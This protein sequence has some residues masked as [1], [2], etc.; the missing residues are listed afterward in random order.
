MS[1]QDA[2]GSRA[3]LV[4]AAVTVVLVVVVLVLGHQQ[5]RRTRE[6][7]AR[8]FNAQQLV[9][10]RYAAGMLTQNWDF[11]RQELVALGHSAALLYPEEGRW[12]ERLELALGALRGRGVVRIER[13]DGRLVHSLEVGGR[14]RVVPGATPPELAGWLAGRPSSGSIHLSP[15]E[16]GRFQRYLRM[17]TPLA[18]G[19]GALSFIIDR[20]ALA[21]KYAGPIRSGRSG[22]A[23]VIDQD[24][25]FLF[26]HEASFI[27]QNAARVRVARAPWLS[28]E[29][30]NRI[31]RELMAAGN[32]GTGSYTSGWHAQVLGRIQKLIAYSPV[33]LA[34]GNR[35]ELWSV[36]VV[37]PVSEAEE[38]VSGLWNTSVLIQVLV[39]GIVL[40]GGV[41]INLSE[42]RWARHLEAE[43]ARQTEGLRASEERYRSLIEN[44]EDIIFT[45]DEQGRYLSM[46]RYGALFLGCPEPERCRGL[47]LEEHFSAE[48]GERLRGLMAEALGGVAGVKTREALEVNG[49]PFTF[50]VHLK[51]LEG[52]QGQTLMAMLRD[53][54]EHARSEEM[55]YRTEK[56]ASIGLLAAGVAH[57]INNPLGAILG[58]SSL[59]L[60]KAA[61]GGQQ[62]HDLKI[63]QEQGQRCKAIVERLLQFGRIAEAGPT[64]RMRTDLNRDIEVAL[65]VARAA[66]SDKKI[67]VEKDLSPHLPALGADSGEMQ[68]VVLNLVNNAAAAMPE[69]GTLRLST[70]CEGPGVVVMQVADN[71]PGIPE[72]HRKRVFD[73]FF[74]TKRV[75]EGTGLGL[76]VT[77]G[78]VS[79]C[80]GTIDFES[81]TRDVWGRSGTTFTI[82]MPAE[83]AEEVSAHG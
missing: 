57:E 52:G 28:F 66:L 49:R 59:L 6:L 37:A 64:A 27:G 80:G 51:A 82:R 58:F 24:C 61:P 22:Y 33:K 18:E 17:S 35:T 26:H 10:A 34:A 40:T 5:A 70:R 63:I 31:Q 14:P 23:W 46:N 75:G 74:T 1:R 36:A 76:S 68:Q 60:G 8:E 29:K 62:E 13:Y 15:A 56:L 9:L 11:L 65:E 44:A 54:T 25:C 3:Q 30:I 81:R 78:I 50:S 16:H 21:A 19:P 79:K 71:G 2:G 48:S 41:Y 43:V 47:F 55:L 73:P 12:P 4:V 83:R 77:Y 69:G 38:A 42:R 32:E 39:I 67:K 53:V 45:L 72:E 20:T 7:A